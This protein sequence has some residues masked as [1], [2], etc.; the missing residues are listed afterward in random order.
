MAKLCVGSNESTAFYY[1]LLD[2]QEIPETA[3]YAGWV[4]NLRSPAH[5]MRRRPYSLSLLPTQDSPKGMRETTSYR[6][7]QAMF[8]A[9]SQ[10]FLHYQDSDSRTVIAL[11]GLMATRERERESAIP[12]CESCE[13]GPRPGVGA[14]LFR[15]GLNVDEKQIYSNAI[16]KGALSSRLK[17]IRQ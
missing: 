11:L 8:S 6:N 16:K 5:L 9:I 15:C 4:F 3:L 17:C 10:F 1:S 14:L 7:S 12:G 2:V 13:G